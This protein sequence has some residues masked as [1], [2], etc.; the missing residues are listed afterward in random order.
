MFQLSLQIWWI[1]DVAQIKLVEARLQPCL[2]G[3]SATILGSLGINLSSILSK[4][5]N[6]STSNFPINQLFAFLKRKSSYGF[7]TFFESVQIRSGFCARWDGLQA[8][9]TNFIAFHSISRLQLPSDFWGTWEKHYLL[10]IIM[11]NTTYASCSLRSQPRAIHSS[12]Y[13]TL[14]AYLGPCVLFPYFIKTQ[15][16]FV[17]WTNHRVFLVLSNHLFASIHKNDLFF[18]ISRNKLGEKACSFKKKNRLSTTKLT[19]ALH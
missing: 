19:T 9:I 2:A 14:F 18:K 10:L 3:K 6:F 5:C 16:C 11:N 4:G 13:F 1:S 12:Y 8:L 17:G 7:I 15:R